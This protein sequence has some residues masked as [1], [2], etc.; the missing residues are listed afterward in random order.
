MQR[1]LRPALPAQ[2]RLLTSL[3]SRD[4]TLLSRYLEP[5]SLALG[6]VLYEPG[7]RIFYVYFPC[8]GVI[9]LLAMVA[10]GKAAEIAVVGDEGVVGGSSALGINVSHFRAVVQGAGTALRIRASDLRKT[11]GRETASYREFYRFTH[12]L[13]QQ[14]AQTAACNRFHR[15]EARLARWLLTTR[16]R[17]HSHQFNLTHEFLSLMLGARRVGVTFAAA[18]LQRRGL[19]SYSRGRIQLLDARGLEAAACECYGT[20]NGMYRQPNAKPPI[21]THR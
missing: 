9:S 5:V 21:S 16:D 15:I 1:T 13:M 12:L 3:P 10:S 7:D 11:F 20:L 8:S 19:I 17:L 2:N 4:F 14:A 6:Q 18:S